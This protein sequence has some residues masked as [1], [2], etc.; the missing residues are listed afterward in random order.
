MISLFETPQ[1]F[2]TLEQL[3]GDLACFAYDPNIKWRKN[4][5]D[6]AF[7]VQFGDKVWFYAVL[8]GHGGVRAA[9]Y[10]MSHIPEAFLEELRKISKFTKETVSEAAKLAFLKEDE[11]WF[12]LGHISGTTFTGALVTPY[13]IFTINLGDSRTLISQG[14]SLYTTVDQ[15]PNDPEEKSRIIKA[16]NFVGL[17]FRGTYRVG[18]ILAISRALGDSY[19]KMKIDSPNEYLGE[20]ASVSPVPIVKRYGRVGNEAILI[21]CDGVFDVIDNDD[22][23]EFYQRN[24]NF[25]YLIYETLFRG[26]EDNITIMAIQL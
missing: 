5:E 1:I 19:L 12:R 7:V 17:D 2:P 25:Q 15:K 16:G 9:E 3:P 8:D 22:V 21:A 11:I 26:S 6:R 13:D 18:G 10:F 24:K 23:M 20:N 4:M 14:D